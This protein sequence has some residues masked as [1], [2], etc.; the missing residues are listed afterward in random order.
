MA[1]IGSED[2]SMKIILIKRGLRGQTYFKEWNDPRLGYKHLSKADLSPIL[3]KTAIDSAFVKKIW[4]PDIELKTIKVKFI[5][6]FF[7]AI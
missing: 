5:S 6:K 1:A 2:C 3:S 4:T 7:F